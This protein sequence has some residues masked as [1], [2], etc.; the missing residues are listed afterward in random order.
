MRKLTSHEIGILE[1]RGCAAEDWNQVMVAEP[2]NPRHYL[3]VHFSGRIE[4]GTTDS[5]FTLDGGVKLPAGIYNSALHNVRVADNVRIAS[6]SNYIANYDIEPYVLIENVNRMVTHRG[7]TFG[8]G[9]NV[10]V[11][12]ET[13][14]RE[15]PIYEQL[16]AQIAYMMAMYRHNP[17]LTAALTAM[18]RR[19]A[20]ES[21]SDRGRVGA[22]ATI[23][24]AGTI[25]DVNI[26]EH[27]VVDGAARLINGTITG[28]EKD[29]VRVGTGVTATNFILASGSK[30]EDNVVL[31]NVFVGQGTHLTHLFSAHDSLF[32]ANCACENGE[33]CAIFAG[34]YTVTMHKSSLLIAGMFSFLNAGSGSNQSNHMY[35]LGPIHQG[36]VERGSKTT[37]DSYVLWPAR[38]GAFSLVMGRHVDHPDTSALPFSY[39]IEKKGRTY[40]VPGVNLK[41]VGTIRDSK[42]WP[43]R[44]KRLDDD[45]LDCI[46]FN[47]LSPYTVERMMGAIRLLNDVESISGPTAEKYAYQNM[48]IESRALRKGRQYYEMAINKFMGNSVLKRLEGM[49]FKTAEDIVAWLRPTNKAGSGEWVDIGGML[50]PKSEISAL[51]KDIIEE[52]VATLSELRRRFARLHAQYYDMEWTWVVEHFP[53]WFGKD[54]EQVSP[55]DV[56]QIVKRWIDSVVA[57]D[58]LLYEDA[59]KEFS[60]VTMTGFGLDGSDGRRRSDFGNVRG[61]FESDPFVTML[62][63]HIRSKTALGKDLTQRI[64]RINAV[65]NPEKPLF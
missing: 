11:L 8:I 21:I 44:D 32:F 24:N 55:S 9:V 14:G 6:V 26:G 39:L 51:I 12:N 2:F 10:A 22:Y 25:A 54:I 34:P 15:V 50:A 23:C 45:L 41:S 28:S 3:N 4:L 63:E 16:T 56:E 40:L 37:S 48:T 27:A 18:V 64:A 49:E 33:A 38:I 35:K 43:K 62:L 61:E 52:R 19:H 42:K 60:M 53:A 65:P 57:L 17:K 47:L 20:E 46:N 36:V 7:A 5:A 59:R 29:P 31:L 58:Q 30:V 13:G 1:S